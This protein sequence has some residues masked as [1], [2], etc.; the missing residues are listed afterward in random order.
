MTPMQRWLA[1]TAA[2]F[3]FALE[4]AAG[5]TN[6]VPWWDAF[7]SYP[8]GTQIDGTNGW[9]GETLTA[10]TVT[11]NTAVTGL[12]TNYTA[13]GGSFPLPGVSCTSV[14]QVAG[15]VVNDIRS[16]TGGVVA[17]EFM[18]LPLWMDVPPPGDTNLQYSLC[19]STNARLTVWHHNLSLATNEWLELTN[20]P[21]I[22]TGAWARFTVV[23]D[24]SNRM[25]Q[26]QVNQGSPVAD[27]AGWTAGGASAG[28]SWFYMVQTNASLARLTASGGPVYLDDVVVTN[29]YLTWTGTGFVESPLNNGTLVAAPITVDAAYETFSG[30]IGENLATNGRVTVTGAPAGLTAVVERVSATRVA[31]TLAQ[32]ALAHEAANS[33]SNLSVRFENG[34]FTHGTVA[35][36]TDCQR[37]NLTV[38]FLDTPRLAW[39]GT[40]FAETA[41]ND[42]S[43]DTTTPVVVS[44]ANGTFAGAVGENFGT[45]AA[46]VS[47]A[48]LPSGLA[49][50]L[51]LLTSTQLEL[52]LTGHAA[53]HE[54]ANSITNLQAI[55][56]DGAFATVPASSVFNLAT[57]LAIAFTDAGV[58]SYAADTFT[59]AAQNNGAV[60]GSS[61]GL[62][63]KTLNATNGEDLVASGKVVATNVP[64]GL[65]LV[66]TASDTRHAALSFSGRAAVH[67]A[68]NSIANLGV[69]FLDTAFVGGNA[70]GVLHAARTDLRIAFNDP[71][72]VSV[73]GAP[74]QEA[75]A[76]NGGIGN[77]VTM[78]LE[79]DT[80]NGG[81]YVAGVHYTVTN[82]P[83]GLTLALAY[84]DATHI[85]ASLSGLAA[86]HAS[87]D[88][89]TNLHVTL[90]DGLF[91]TV[92]AANISGTA[93]D[94]AVS[95]AD[96]ASLAYNTNTF[97][98]LAAGY[99]DN[100]SPVIV[101]VSG[102]TFAGTNGQDLAASGLLVAG[103]LPTGL[104]AQATRDGATQ[105]SIRLNG[106]AASHASTDS[107]TNVVFAFQAGA[108]TSVAW[109]Q[110]VNYQAAGFRI[111]FV[112]DTGFFNV[113]PYVEPFEAYANGLCLAGTN[114][115][116]GTFADSA[117]ITNDPVINGNVRAYLAA[118]HS[119]LP[120]SGTH[121]QL[122]YVQSP[123]AVAVHSEST[124]L[125]YVDFMTLPVGLQADPGADTNLQYAFYVSTN[126]QLVVWHKNRTGV[127][128][129]EWL[130][131]AGAGTID[132]TR[133]TRFTVALDYTHNMYQV[134]VNEGRPLVDAAGW[135]AGGAS[136][137]G[138]WF[139]MVQTNGTLSTLRM[140]GVGD[141]YL[142]DLTVRTSLPELFGSRAGSVFKFQ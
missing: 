72:V 108:F 98:E 14:L 29:R 128:V 111:A 56:Q 96:P 4:A 36:V 69:R 58:L 23:H 8:D 49:G 89:I 51:T 119:E 60:D 41:A 90:G 65:A 50:Q 55:L 44:L 54:A 139:Y 81:P 101:T 88:S 38:T 95:F 32:A 47:F 106:A 120:V 91:A 118:G 121:T 67:A 130:T 97:H 82:V 21:S 16:A 132:T 57:N 135:T 124:R 77:A 75:A 33:I 76:N 136:P 134:Q 53:V 11:T 62:T 25:F 112:D 13:G 79:G 94:L 59:E 17:T 10:G 34:A 74:F 117:V 116:S 127:P 22:A 61:L 19:V 113:L 30:G 92:S 18:A 27:S 26:V 129:N 86:A 3:G 7:E 68:A 122:L 43:L 123:V 78:A 45:N 28:G 141:G 114:G 39:T 115:W 93:L 42:G 142:D 15:Q 12:L 64:A 102:D 100:R 84:V 80:F 110:V 131:L 105:V 109:N 31:I 125:A 37:T 66:V 52:R 40:G 71:P 9:V 133:W 138:S 35:G 137:T 126:S 5:I 104:T 48:N 73:S 83:A 2:T 6:A 63:N 99:I 140:T 24:Y 1:I 70:A 46:K 85:A 20:S 107:V 103:N 87:A